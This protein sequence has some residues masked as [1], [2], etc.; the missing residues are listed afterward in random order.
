MKSVIS[1]EIAVLIDNMSKLPGL[2]ARSARRIVFAMINRKS[3]LLKPLINSMEVVASKTDFCD[4]CG[5]IYTGS[6]CPVC[7]DDQRDTSVICVV[8]TIS[9]MWAMDRTGNFEG[10]YHILG[11]VLSAIN[12]VGPKDLK[13]PKLVERCSRYDVKE[14]ILALNATVDAQTTIHVICDMLQHTSV[15]IST[16][17]CGIPI[18]GELDYLDDGT[19][20]MAMKSRNTLDVI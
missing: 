9:D 2:G 1:K 19:I 8:E 20:I 14:V 10:L 13:I 12:G 17:A 4:E 7:S 11:G 6:Q 16:L 3:Q 18:G 15:K 5:N